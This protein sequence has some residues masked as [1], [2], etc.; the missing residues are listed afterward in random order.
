[1]NKLPSRSD[2]I[3]KEIESFEDYEFSNNIAYEMMIRNS[4]FIKD[5]YVLTVKC[6]T[7]RIM[8]EEEEYEI[9][10]KEIDKDFLKLNEREKAI[11]YKELILMYVDKY[12]I[13]YNDMMNCYNKEYLFLH[14]SLQ[15]KIGNKNIEY[16]LPKD[17]KITPDDNITLEY[18]LAF[19]R[20]KI[21][22]KNFSKITQIS[23][24]LSLPKNELLEYISKIKDIADNGDIK[25]PIELLGENLQKAECNF[26]QNK[27]KRYADMF[28]IYD[29]VSARLETIH[30]YNKEARRE[31][32]NEVFE[33]NNNPSLT[34]K[35][36]QIQLSE[37]KTKYLQNTI[38]TKITD[39]FN[40]DELISQLQLTGN[41]ISK[42]YY[43]IKPYIEEAKYKELITGI[44]QL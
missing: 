13:S 31:Y 38:D 39:I 16:D 17:Y 24:N 10:M 32:D 33:I 15:Y 27:K 23:L 26:K 37:A 5:R 40:E 9:I 3:Y 42:L 2:E 36:K 29:Y 6:V 28:F 19:K 30:H 1:M 12:G 8:I 18:E 4:D 34:R 7:F 11:H 43:I 35:Y 44:K 20:P 21:Q 22:I 14:N 25:A 41:S